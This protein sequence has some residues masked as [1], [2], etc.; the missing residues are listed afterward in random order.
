MLRVVLFAGR[1]RR[2]GH[3]CGQARGART[4]EGKRATIKATVTCVKAHREVL[5]QGGL[6]R[7]HSSDA[8]AATVNKNGKVTA[9]AGGRRDLGICEQRR[10]S[11]REGHGEVNGLLSPGHGEKVWPP[12][13][14]MVMYYV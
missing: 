13:P 1:G 9:V 2:A 7:F 12:S 14:Y 10:K 6:A 8:N 11:R 4:D 5:K 3:R